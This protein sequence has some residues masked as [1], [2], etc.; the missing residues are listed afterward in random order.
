MTPNYLQSVGALA[1]AALLCG[2]ATTGPSFAESNVVCQRKMTACINSC[3]LPIPPNGEKHSPACVDRCE[4]EESVCN[5]T[6]GTHGP[7]SNPPEAEKRK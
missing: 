7:I 6:R 3:P 2:L 1:L 4:I 5:S